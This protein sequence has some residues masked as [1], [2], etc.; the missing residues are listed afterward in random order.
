[1]GLNLLRLRC[2]ADTRS[3][4]D[5]SGGSYVVPGLYQGDNQGISFT[6]KQTEAGSLVDPSVLSEVSPDSYTLRIGLFTVAGTQLAYQNT[7][8]KSGNSYVGSIALN[9]AAIA[10]ALGSQTQVPAILEIEVIDGDSTPQTTTVYQQQVTLYREYITTGTIAVPPSE[11]AATEAWASGTFVK[12]FM[13]P[14]EVIVLLS[15]NGTYG[16]ELG[17]NDDGTLKANT[18]TI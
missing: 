18:I 17:V 10:T 13:A 16:I 7:W 8:V 1:M 2:V 9:T 6:L 14:G 5:D 3:L 12:K 4:V 11:V 15:A